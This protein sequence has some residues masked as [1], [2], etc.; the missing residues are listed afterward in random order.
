MLEVV[1]AMSVEDARKMTVS[2]LQRLRV[3]AMNRA[4]EEYKKCL[5]DELKGVD[6][7]M[8]EL[9]KDMEGRTPFQSSIKR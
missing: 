7:K 8:D 6:G 9:K 4:L 1:C 2:E 5:E 3:V